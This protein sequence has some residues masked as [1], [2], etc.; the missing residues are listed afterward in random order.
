MNIY[1]LVREFLIERFKPCDEHFSFGKEDTSK[2]YEKIKYASKN[3]PKEKIRESI[4][5]AFSD[6]F[7]DCAKVVVVFKDE[8]IGVKLLKY[9]KPQD[10]NEIVN[11]IALFLQ[12]AQEKECA[13]SSEAN[14]MIIHQK[15][16]DKIKT[17]FQNKNSVTLIEGIW[18]KR[19]MN[20]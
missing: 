17:F 4:R 16:I 1:S 5:E 15:C 2:L 9:E 12:T 7:I 14:A 11:N 20:K 18:K 19:E 10:E 3:I 8:D 6:F 13:S